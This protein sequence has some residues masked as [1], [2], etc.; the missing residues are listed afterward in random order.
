MQ[1]FLFLKIAALE[2]VHKI[3]TELICVQR[4]HVRAKSNITES[5]EVLEVN[6]TKQS[7][8]FDKC[9]EY[10]H[11]YISVLNLRVIIRDFKKKQ[12][13]DFNNL[14]HTCITRLEHLSLKCT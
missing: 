3:I 7:Q 2:C 8:R 14:V 10:L 5:R 6:I 9:I 12:I 13:Y 1:Y 11:L 4:R